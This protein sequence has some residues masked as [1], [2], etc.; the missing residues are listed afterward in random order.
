MSRTP[1]A[2]DSTRADRR[3]ARRRLLW[4]LSLGALSLVFVGVGTLHF[5]RPDDF[6]AI[7]PP[8]LPAPLLLVYV[9]GVAEIGLGL[10]VLH[11]RTRRL[12]AWGLVALLIAVYPAN[13]YHA[14]AD[15]P[16]G[17]S[18]APLVYHVVRLPLQLVLIWW[19]WR[20]TR[21]RRAPVV[22]SMA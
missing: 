15:V 10:A 8:F 1:D 11:P 21:P 9:S 17:G 3:R 16:V 14:V 4:Q 7:I 19:A 22:A 20:F 12:A 2:D 13:I 6:V 5:V 18:H